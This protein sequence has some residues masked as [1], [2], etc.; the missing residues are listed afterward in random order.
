MEELRTALDACDGGCPNE[1]FT[2]AIFTGD[3]DSEIIEFGL[4]Q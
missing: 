1:H 3:P 4:F 2:K